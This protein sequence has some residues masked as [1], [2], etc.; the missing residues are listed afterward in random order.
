MKDRILIEKYIENNLSSIEKE[1][2]KK[3]LKSDPEFREFLRKHELLE[4][5]LFKFFQSEQSEKNI[6]TNKT[7]IYDENYTPEKEE[8]FKKN[9][10]KIIKNNKKDKNNYLYFLNIAA[11][12]AFFFIIGLGISNQVKKNKKEKFCDSLYE[13]Y[14]HPKNDFYLTEEDREKYP[15]L[16]ELS[17]KNKNYE[18]F[19]TR[20]IIRGNKT[21][22]KELLYIAVIHIIKDENFSAIEILKDIK[23]ANNPDHSDLASWYYSIACLKQGKQDE[24]LKELRIL[25]ERQNPYKEKACQLLSDITEN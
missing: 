9:L 7:R 13:K 16:D 1:L 21:N 10:Q 24:C 6:T 11:T 23:T 18:Y 17:L 4:G 8:A 14:F 25:C 20:D 12:I 22:L 3:K 19:S 2:F 15:G 5:L